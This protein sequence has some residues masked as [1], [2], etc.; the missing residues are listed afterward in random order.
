MG[1]E[2]GPDSGVSLPR[3]LL[4]LFTPVGAGTEPASIGLAWSLPFCF[5]Q[6]QEVGAKTAASEGTLTSM[7]VLATEGQARVRV[8]RRE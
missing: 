2:R 8:S 6:D 5:W 7:G 3:Q 1:S 4:A